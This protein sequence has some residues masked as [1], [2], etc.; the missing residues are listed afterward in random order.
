MILLPGS[1]WVHGARLWRSTSGDDRPDTEHLLERNGEMTDS[2]EAGAL[3]NA[4]RS[5]LVSERS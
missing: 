5:A 4:Q 3:W 1:E 2:T